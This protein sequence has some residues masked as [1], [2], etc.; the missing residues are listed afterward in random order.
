MSKKKKKVRSL[1]HQVTFTFIGLLLLSIL[2][3]FII[4]GAFLEKYYVSKKIET[5]QEAMDT[6]SQI[7]T[8]ELADDA[9][10]G[11]EDSDLPSEIVQAS[12]RNNLT[13]VVINDDNSKALCWPEKED[14]LRSKLFFGYASDL[15]LDNGKGKI[16]KETDDYV[17]QQVHDRFAGMDYVECWGEFDKSLI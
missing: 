9:S 10:S 13:W 11:N 8:E 4:N 3:I 17:V 12:S 16:L 1:Q 2:T 6:L 5:L 7:T 14:Q 15:D